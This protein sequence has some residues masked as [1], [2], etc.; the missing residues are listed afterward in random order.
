MERTS[1]A[2]GVGRSGK[3]RIRIPDREA[4]ESAAC[5]C[6]ATVRDFTAR[7]MSDH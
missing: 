4:M 7:L 6:Y 1:P 5:E 3:L 2:G